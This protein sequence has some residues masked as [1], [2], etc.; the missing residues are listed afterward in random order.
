M[1]GVSSGARFSVLRNADVPAVLIEGGFL[2]NPSEAARIASTSWRDE[3]AEGV[4]NGILAY[5]A[6]VD[7]GVVPKSVEALGGKATTEFVPTN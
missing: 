4:V 2:T 5:I 6:L 7:K 1:I 3:L